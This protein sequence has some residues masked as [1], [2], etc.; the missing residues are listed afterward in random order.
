MGVIETTGFRGWWP[1]REFCGKDSQGRKIVKEGFR[2]MTNGDFYATERGW[3]DAPPYPTGEIAVLRT[4]SETYRENYDK[5]RWNR[6][7]QSQ[8]G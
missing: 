4:A 1:L 6:D 3:D 7:G 2:N 5:I 8:A